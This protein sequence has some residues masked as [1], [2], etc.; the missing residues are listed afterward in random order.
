MIHPTVSVI[1]A[2]L[3]E[4]ATIDHVLEIARTDPR[5]VEVIVADGGS[6]DTTVDRVRV[7]A[8][9]DPRVRLVENPDRIQSA[10]LNAA[11]EMATGEVLVRL[12]AHTRY[13][14]DYVTASIDAWRPGIAVGGPMTAE[15]DT[16]WE[17]AIA[18]AMADPLAIGPAR[19]HH[20]KRVEAVD[21]VYLG[22]FERRGFLELGGYR[23]FPSG[24]VEDTDFY[25][26]WH[27]SGR[28]VWVDPSIRSWY[29]PRSTW[30]QLARQYLR[31]GRGKAEL[32]W[33]NRRFPSFRP[34]APALLIAGLVVGLVTGLV[35][36]CLPL[37]I[38]VSA[39][40]AALVV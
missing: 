15:G 26:R 18:A 31:Y 8:S 30:R 20:A 17:R 35:W 16:P 38:L 6:V 24:T 14:H 40:L 7:V 29:R 12:D 2:T 11:A 36:S 3:D 4:A 10:G 23:T 32:L 39:W 1:I 21:T 27:A 22:T 37:A 33:V 19:F 34:L 25:T 9:S 28:T 5:V 13:E